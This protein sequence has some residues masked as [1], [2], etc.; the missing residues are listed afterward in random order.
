MDQT[1][2]VVVYCCGVIRPYRSVTDEYFFEIKTVYENLQVQSFP[3]I[4]YP[5]DSLQSDAIVSGL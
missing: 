3:D 1:K 4:V 2:F 5:R